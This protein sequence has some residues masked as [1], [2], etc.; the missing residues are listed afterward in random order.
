MNAIMNVM[1][2]IWQ[3]KIMTL[4][5]VCEILAVIAA[6]LSSP[7]IPTP[8]WLPYA[9]LLM[10]TIGAAIVAGKVAW[11]YHG[12][13]LNATQRKD[14][15]D[16][17]ASAGLSE[18]QTEGVQGLLANAN[19]N[20]TQIDA[21]AEAIKSSGLTEHQKS[22]LEAAIQDVHIYETVLAQKAMAEALSYVWDRGPNLDFRHGH[23]VVIDRTH[24]GQLDVQRVESPRPQEVCERQH[25]DESTPDI[26][27]LEIA[28]SLFQRLG[29]PVVLW[30]HPGNGKLCYTNFHNQM[31][32]GRGLVFNLY[33]CVP[34]WRA[35]APGDDVLTRDESG[36]WTWE[37]RS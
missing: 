29:T 23:V 10:A 21:V 30:M 37:Q 18:S 35:S 17:L 27:T 28:K 13:G 34:E 32:R 6:A 9:A 11:D 24:T 36:K 5:V 7:A 31:F 25:E 1:M 2:T 4:G 12:R 8:G 20:A 14:V 15:Q 26:N 33:D 19:L 22:E 16:I 3:S